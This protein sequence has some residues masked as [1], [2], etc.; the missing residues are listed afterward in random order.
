MKNKIIKFIA[1]SRLIHFLSSLFIRIQPKF[2]QHNLSKYHQL[3]K[4]IHT[5]I[6][7]GMKNTT[8]I[9]FGCFT[10]AALYHAIRCDY[11]KSIKFYGLDSLEGFPEEVHDVFKSDDF[12]A[13]YKF[14]KKLEEKFPKRV[15]II[16]GY[17]DDSL[18]LDKMKKIDNISLAFID[19][20]LYSSTKPVV[21]Y[22]KNRLENGAFI[23]IDDFYNIDKNG[24]SIK[25]I[26][27]KY[28]QINKNIFHCGYFGIH[29]SVFRYF[30][31]ENF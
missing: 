5:L 14:V 10:G 11:S 31:N 22:L 16:K 9:E 4:L 3:N 12:K 30:K 21:E 6:M 20:D 19:C 26:F 24:R 7:D 25:D 29:G 13:D 27:F 17:F 28:F 23:M 1:N 18:N 2:I 8:Y 15:E